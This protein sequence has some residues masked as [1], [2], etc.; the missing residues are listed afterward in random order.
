MVVFAGP[1]PQLGAGT[2]VELQ[3]EG[4]DWPLRGRFVE[5]VAT[6]SQIQ[7]VLNHDHVDFMERVMAR[8]SEAA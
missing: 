5:K 7:L 1:L 6:G 2:L 8:L 3:I 4:L